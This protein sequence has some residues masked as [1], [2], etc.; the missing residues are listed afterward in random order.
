MRDSDGKPLTRECGKGGDT[1][2]AEEGE[3]V[4]STCSFSNG[5]VARG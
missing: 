5:G 3:I 4:N 1:R 2:G